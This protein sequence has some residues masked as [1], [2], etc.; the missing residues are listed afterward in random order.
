MA[1]MQQQQ[2]TQPMMQGMGQQ[3]MTATP[4]AMAQPMMAGMMQPMAQPM[5]QQMAQPMVQAVPT[6]MQG[7]VGGVAQIP[8]VPVGQVAPQAATAT[9]ASPVGA[10]VQRRPSDGGGADWSVPQHS[11]LKYTQVFNMTDRAKS[12]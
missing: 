2:A 1:G 12:G 9:A 7:S 11:K 6:A 3:G 8:S 4:P 5:A 10:A